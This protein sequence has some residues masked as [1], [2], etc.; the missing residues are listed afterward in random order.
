MRADDGLAGRTERR[1]GAGERSRRAHPPDERH[2]SRRELLRLGGGALAL[3][4]FGG[5]GLLGCSGSRDRL[6]SAPYLQRV[7]TTSAVVAAVTGA[8]ERLVLRWGAAGGRLDH[9]VEEPEPTMFHRLEATGLTASGRYAYQLERA[10]GQV[11]GGGAF[12]SARPPG[13]AFTFAAVGDSGGTERS[14]GEV[15]D[16]LDEL[17]AEVRGTAAD[18]NQQARVARVLAASP[19]E[20]V[21]HT[22]DVVYPDGALDDYPEAF[23]RPF[24]AV[25]ASR[26]IVP[27]L[28]NHDAKTGGG[29][30]FADVFLTA[31]EGPVPDGRAR[32][33]DWG[34]CHFTVLDVVATSFDPGSPQAAWA[35]QD[36]LESDRRWKVVVFHVPPIRATRPGDY[37]VMALV[38]TL[39]RAGADL[40]VCGHDHVYARYF[41]LGGLTCVT[42]GGGGKNLYSVRSDERLAYGESVFHV[43]EVDVTPARLSLR[44]VDATGRVFDRTEID[45]A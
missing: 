2:L 24:A 38:P 40:L 25:G 43:V 14:R 11:L 27:A 44:A 42:T 10:G 13:E 17:Q 31:G 34:D 23:F 21:L 4:A 9:A 30:P 20:L 39:Q 6:D 37:E 28:G 26:P 41:P 15:I 1:R 33:F 3:G 35:E 19:A 36:L 7:T 29:R 12:T 5:A 8:P 45:K 18:E 32:S 16:E 22:G